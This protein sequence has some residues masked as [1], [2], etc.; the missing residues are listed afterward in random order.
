MRGG[1]EGGY[2]RGRRGERRGRR[3][4]GVSGSLLA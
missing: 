1:S 4:I 3:G 2:R